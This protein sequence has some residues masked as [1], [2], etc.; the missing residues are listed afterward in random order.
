MV[1]ISLMTRRNLATS[2]R[3]LLLGLGSALLAPAAPRRASAAEAPKKLLLRAAATKIALRPGQPETSIWSLEGPTPGLPLRVKRGDRIEMTLQND[4][5]ARIAFNLRGLDGA[6]AAEPLAAR[7]PL[8][9]GA[10]AAFGVSFPR[11]GSLVCDIRLLADGSG[12]PSRA[13]PLVVEDAGM[14]SDRDEVFLVED[15]RLQEDGT[16]VPPGTDARGIPPLFTVNGRLLPEFALRSRE[17]L[18]VRFINGCQRQV[19][20]LKIEG[21]DVRVMALD[22]QPSEPFLARNSALVLAPDGRADALIDVTPSQGSTA[23]VLLHDGKEARPVARL[24][25]P[26][27]PPVRTAPLPPAPPLPS[28]GLPEKLDLRNALRIDLPLAGSEW[29]TPATFGTSA[30]PAFRAKTS[31]IVVL[32]LINRAATATVFHLHGHHFRLLDR[33]DDGWKPYWLDTLAVEPGQTERIAFSAE[34]AGRWLV[35]ATATDWA[36]PKLLRWYSVD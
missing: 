2:R 1:R 24:V 13:L 26:T 25:I 4:L 17:R 16:A 6:L 31:R 22:S 30:A 29:V 9:P 28:N 7:P 10:N 32:A 18:R 21:H 11:S 33:L 23:T 19:I 35:E 14:I 27:D 8:A 12:L 3:A 36:A 5:P 20:A 34:Y 15:W